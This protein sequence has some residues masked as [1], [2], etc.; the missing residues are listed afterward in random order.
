MN[1][2]TVTI[3]WADHKAGDV[4]VALG[5]LRTKKNV[6]IVESRWILWNHYVCKA[7]LSSV[8]V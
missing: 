7:L 6:K 4:D 2:E 8:P 5:T 1:R 3:G